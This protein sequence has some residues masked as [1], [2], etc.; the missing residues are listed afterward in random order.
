[1]RRPPNF[2]DAISAQPLH[3]LAVR[4]FLVLPYRPHGP[5]GIKLFRKNTERN[6]TEINCAKEND[7][8]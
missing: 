6:K 8:I 3:S 4:A 7:N 5:H 1:M 2:F